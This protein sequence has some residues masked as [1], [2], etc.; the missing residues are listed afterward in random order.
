MNRPAE[1]IDALLR[2]AR[3]GHEPARAQLVAAVRDQVVRWALVM[4]GDPDDAEDVAQQVSIVLHQKLAQFDQR[5]RFTTWLYVIVRSAVGDLMRKGSR[6]FE[7]RMDEDHMPQPI[8]HETEQRLD[9]IGEQEIAAIVRSFFRILSPRQRELIELIDT[10][11]RT[12]N[13]AAEMMGI[14]PETARVHLLRARRVLRAEILQAYPEIL[15]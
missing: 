6:R 5:S 1:N 4:T 3:A 9:Q 15:A 13:E 12:A 11:G 2:K 10:E 8:S 7:I 14:E